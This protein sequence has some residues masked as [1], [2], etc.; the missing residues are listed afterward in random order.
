MMIVSAWLSSGFSSEYAE[1]DREDKDGCKG[2]S[3][4]TPI[5]SARRGSCGLSM[6]HVNLTQRD[7]GRLGY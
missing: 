3:F 5:H 7:K 4:S 1:T 2:Y 6:S